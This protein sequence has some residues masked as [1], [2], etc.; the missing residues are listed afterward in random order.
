MHSDRL[1]KYVQWMMGRSALLRKSPVVQTIPNYLLHRQYENQNPFLL[2]V[3]SQGKKY[4]GLQ[5]G[6]CNLILS[7]R[8]RHNQAKSLSTP[9]VDATQNLFSTQ[10]LALMWC[11]IG[12]LPG[13]HRLHRIFHLR[14][15]SSFCI[16]NLRNQDHLSS[17]SPTNRILQPVE[18]LNKLH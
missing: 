6:Q 17:N 8:C 1:N 16:Q 12:G 4:M 7:F 2:L 3:D 13:T 14:I 15:E 5:Q 11:N 10:V 9:I 18:V